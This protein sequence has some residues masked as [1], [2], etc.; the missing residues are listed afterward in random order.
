[1]PVISILGTKGGVGKSTVAMG[2]TCWLSKLQEGMVLLIDGD[3]HVRTVE[4]KMCP[5]T[6]LTLSH[7][8]EGKCSLADAVYACQ[9]RADGKPL[10]PRLAILPAGGRFLP[11]GSR[12]MV[13]FVQTTI[14]RFERM[15]SVLRKKFPYIIV[16]TP[17]SVGF[18]HLILTAIADGLLYVVNPDVDSILSAKQTALGL[19][20]LLG[21]DG[22]GVVLNRVP[23]NARVEEWTIQAEEIARVLGVVEDDELV[24]DAFRRDLPV[25]ALYPEAPASL[26]LRSVASELMRLDIPATKLAPKFE[27]ALGKK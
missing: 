25:V 4:L 15:L 10:F 11:P 27:L 3:I 5:G 23:R 14:R 18:E 2:I 13:G 17:A 24:E 12:D 22:I 1:M 8:L 6:D 9:L 16:D 21:L 19:K 7:F 26:A 20:Q